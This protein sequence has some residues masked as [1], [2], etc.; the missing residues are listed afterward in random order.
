MM[1]AVY[2][3]ETSVSFNMAAWHYSPEDPKLHVFLLVVI[4]FVYSLAK[5]SVLLWNM[6]KSWLSVATS[7]SQRT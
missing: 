6:F 5:E 4:V 2:S 1:E 3:S 7:Y